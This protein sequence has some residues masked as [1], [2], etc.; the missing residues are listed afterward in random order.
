MKKNVIRILEMAV[1]ILSTVLAFVGCS[2]SA[3]YVYDKTVA[4]EQSSVIEL[5]D[6][7]SI[8]EFDGKEVA[9]YG[10]LWQINKIQIPAGEHT[11]KSG[12]GITMRHT[13]LPGD[14]YR[15]F[16]VVLKGER[17]MKIIGTS[18][19][20]SMSTDLTVDPEN[21]DVTPFDGTWV[22]TT[23]RFETHHKITFANGEFIAGWEN[24]ATDRLRG[25]FTY[26]ENKI[27]LYRC[28][29]YD[30][31][32]F[33]SLDNTNAE[34]NYSDDTIYFGKYGK[35]DTNLLVGLDHKKQ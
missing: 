9:W 2:S 5:Y 12:S 35:Q 30:K 22:S 8:V 3:P 1:I 19:L 29:K 17:S 15:I 24:N 27:Y 16:D 34:F 4:A 7:Y 33:L 21:H 20:L 13:F 11:V 10:E 31:R 18:D 6:Y 26:D 32:W 25:Y 28:Y 14:T 23:T